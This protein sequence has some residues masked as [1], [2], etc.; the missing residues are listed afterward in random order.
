MLVL[1][2]RVTRIPITLLALDDS[3]VTHL[4]PIWGRSHVRTA[5]V[6]PAILDAEVKKLAAQR[7][8]QGKI[9]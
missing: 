9:K 2:A 5:D 3:L 8:N 4:P 1:H 6:M 7:K